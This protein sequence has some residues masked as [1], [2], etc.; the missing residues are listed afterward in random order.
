M[1]KPISGRKRAADKEP[2][3]ASVEADAASESSEKSDEE[4]VED[5]EDDDAA[6]SDDEV[7]C[8]SKLSVEQFAMAAARIVLSAEGVRKKVKKEKLTVAIID[9]FRETKTFDESSLSELKLSSFPEVESVLA[10]KEVRMCSRALSSA[11]P[12]W[13][14]GICTSRR[15]LLGLH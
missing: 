1:A 6:A 5:S 14:P 4:S 12:R 9:L 11:Q 3:A 15:I 2:D 10:H 13:C 8:F 7:Q